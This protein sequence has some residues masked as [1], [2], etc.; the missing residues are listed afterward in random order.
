MDDMSMTQWRQNSKFDVGLD[1]F[2]RFLRP[3]ALGVAWNGAI[4]MVFG[5]SW[6]AEATKT[7][8]FFLKHLTTGFGNWGHLSWK[9]HE[10]Y[11][12]KYWIVLIEWASCCLTFLFHQVGLNLMFSTKKTPPLHN[13]SPHPLGLGWVINQVVDT[14]TRNCSVGNSQRRLTKNSPQH[15]EPKMAYWI[16]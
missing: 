14:D 9:K 7:A 4:V 13:G 6:D 3:M 15:L 2:A 8:C 10:D 11:K 12:S 5:R 1:C 16:I